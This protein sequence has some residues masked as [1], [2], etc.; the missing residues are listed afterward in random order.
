MNDKTDFTTLSPYQND[1]WIQELHRPGTPQLTISLVQQL[2]ETTDY[3]RL[4]EIC[5]QVL[6]E[7]PAL[8][9]RFLDRQGETRICRVASEA[10]IAVYT[11]DNTPE[12]E[13]FLEAWTLRCWQPEEEPLIEVAILRSPHVSGILM[14]AHHVLSD[15]WGLN[16]LIERIME[17]YGEGRYKS[18]LLTLARRGMKTPSIWEGAFDALLNDIVT[19][20]PALFPAVTRE[21]VYQPDYFK[22]IF[23]DPAALKTAQNLGFSPLVMVGAC[24][25]VL[26]SNLHNRTSFFLGVPCLNRTRDIVDQVIHRANTLP[27]IVEASPDITLHEVA[28]YFRERVKSLKRCEHVPLGKLISALPPTYP[29]RQLFDVTVSYVHVPLS[30]ELSSRRGRINTHIGDA[31]AILISKGDGDDVLVDFSLAPAAFTDD[32]RPEDFVAALEMLMTRFAENVERPVRDIDIQGSL[33]QQQV[34]QDFEQGEARPLPQ[35]RTVLTAFAEAVQRVPDNI[36]VRD[37]QGAAVSYREL[38]E[39]SSAIAGLLRQKGIVRGDIVAVGLPRSAAMVAAMYGVIRAGAAYLPLDSE[40]PVERI[41]HMLDDSRAKLLIADSSFPF[42]GDGPERLD[43]ADIAAQ[44]LPAADRIDLSEPDGLAYVIY[45]SGST[46][47][48]KGVMIEHRA[49]LNRLDWMQ[50]RYALKETDVILQKTPISFD[51]SVWELFWWAMQGASVALPQPGAQRDPREIARAIERFGVTLLHFVPSMFELYVQMLWQDRK[52]LA[53]SRSVARIFTSGEALVPSLVNQFRRLYENARLTLP[54]LSNLYGPT[55]AAIDVSYH[56]IAFTRGTDVLEVP[57]GRPVHNTRLRV[58]SAHGVRQPVGVVGE[59]QIAGVQLARGYLNQP[60]LTAEKFIQADDGQRWY[61]TGDLA[62]WSR[63]GELLYRGRIDGQVKIRGNRIE[64]GEIRRCLLTIP[65]VTGAEVIVGHD[66]ARGNHLVAFY[67]SAQPLDHGLVRESLAYQLPAF[68]LPTVIRWIDGIPLTLNGKVD[69]QAL[70]AAL[71]KQASAPHARHSLTAAETL[72]ADVWREVLGV[73]EIAAGDD[74]FMLGG[75]SLLMLKVRSKLEERGYGVNLT[76]MTRHTTVDGLARLLERPLD[77]PVEPV[78]PLSPFELVDDAEKP[79]LADYVDAYPLSRLQLGLIYHSLETAGSRQYKDVF[80]Y[81]LRMEWDEERFGTALATLIA[82]HPALR[83]IFD[84]HRFSQ[85]MQLICPD[86]AIER[87]LSVQHVAASERDKLIRRWM[88]EMAEHHYAFEQAPPY[89]VT[90]FI[91]AGSDEVELVLNF[92]H[93]LLDGGSVAN[94]LSELLLE[95]ATADAAALGYPPAELP[96]PSLFIRNEQKALESEEQRQYWRDYLNGAPNTS[97][98]ALARYRSPSSYRQRISRGLLLEQWLDTRL[99]QMSLSERIPVRSLLLTAHCVVIGLLSASSEVV[100]GVVTH[101]RP[102]LK[103]SER[104]LGLFLNTLPVRFDAEGKSWRE[105][106]QALHEAERSHHAHRQMPLS[107]I[108]ELNPGFTLNTAFNYIHYHMLKDA[109]TG[110][111][112]ELTGFEPHEETNFTLLVNVMRDFSTDRTML[113]VDLDGSQLAEEQA[114]HYLA[115]F[116]QVLERMALRPE[117]PARLSCLP[118]EIGFSWSTDEARRFVPVIEHIRERVREMPTAVAIRH[119]ENSWTYQELWANSGQI[120]ARLQEQ[121]VDRHAVVGIAL[122]RSPQLIATLLATLRLGAACLP[123]DVAYP[124]SR[125]ADIIERAAPRLIAAP[126]GM[127]ADWLPDGLRIT[128]DALETSMSSRAD[129]FTEP[130]VEEDDIAYILFTSGS[131]GRPKGVAM[132]Q[133]ALANMIEWQNTM[134]SGHQVTST[135]QYAPL[136]FDVSFQEIFSTLCAG[137]LLCLIDEERRRDPVALLRLIAEQRIERVFLPYVALQQM[138]ETATSLNLIPE[139]LRILISAGEQLRVTDEIRRFIGALR[140]GILENHYGPTET[141]VV[142]C[143]RMAGQ[144]D[145]FP[146]LPPIGQPIANV[147][148]LILNDSLEVVPDGVCGELCFFGPALAL[149]YYGDPQETEKK[150]FSLPAP[151]NLRIYRTGDTGVRLASGEIVCLGR[152]DSQIKVRGYRVEPAE[153]EIRALRFLESIGVTS[154]LA[155]LARTR[156]N[157][158]AYLVLYLTGTPDDALAARLQE[159]LAA[160]LPSYMLPSAI[161]WVEAIPRTPSGKRDDAALRQREPVF[162]PAVARAPRNECEAR[163]CQMLGEL[164]AFPEISPEQNIFDLGATSLTAMRVVVMVEKVY[165]VN[166]PLAAFIKWPTVS[167]LAEI[168]RLG[169]QD[170]QPFDPLVPMRT[171]GTNRPIFMVHPMGGN[172]LSYLKMLRH[173]PADQPFYALQSPGVEAGSAPLLGI[174]NQADLYIQAIKRVQPEGPYV[175]AGWSYGGF[176]AFEMARRLLAAG[177]RVER[178]IVL[179]TILPDRTSR[180]NFSD[181]AL[182]RWFFWEL[183]WVSS[184]ADIT[185]ELIPETVTSLQQRFDYMADYAVRI[186]ALPAGSDSAAIQR[187]F[188]VYRTNWRSAELFENDRAAVDIT[189]IRAT[190]PL[191]VALREMHERAGTRY[192]DPC[193]GWCNETSGHIEVIEVDGDHLTIMEEPCVGVVVERIVELLNVVQEEVV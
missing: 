46:G 160:S 41:A 67:V 40:Y 30:S 12:Q 73:N 94:L 3:E 88:W 9:H 131:T 11:F 91:A 65:G 189:L 48:P 188:D 21:Q 38:D 35:G 60:E 118:E 39:W 4:R 33:A 57:I 100:T 10:E 6:Q 13:R 66:E 62:C 115:L 101:A 51:V 182:L 69:H 105:C 127:A 140:D 99:Q 167:R 193:N 98:V 43:I 169:R 27:V 52:S 86:L 192:D 163:L 124:P 172:V 141:H 68:M 92:H 180:E 135:L 112:I 53:A 25:M 26:L 1:V 74:F 147:G 106:V 23:I 133:R 175:L 171:A 146:G 164:L 125:L 126:H 75:D 80:R 84:L 168:I 54:A 45:T 120:A 129:G 121:G 59:L 183:L 184:G 83:T 156:G 134:P 64:L 151:L 158:D 176:V 143:H 15:A 70:R 138:A 136:S 179:D 18:R 50:E 132:P 117:A 24:L 97:P 63:D 130:A 113:R 104:L 181:D 44:K 32:F 34:T 47:Q 19:V 155:V 103:H 61:R 58:V 89:G 96:S 153:V 116:Q 109:F 157:N 28:A 166:V 159:A 77:V 42:G 114:G 119:G 14:R 170:E 20:E 110:K 144:V 187:L 149:G 165:G 185:A 102:E 128:V 8:A 76:D 37:A 122:E 190:Q 137:G 174:G 142:T 152:N 16:V 173:L 31:A 71:A 93:A 162:R 5:R 191:P 95:Y 2:P 56:D 29:S 186:G 111:G 178:L 123:L 107:A 148:A 90:V 154:E 161:E 82:R 150:F 79:L 81:T 49:L 78:R 22:R 87:V 55:E 36:A 85:P 139:S 177:E 72:V 108:A 145:D 7:E 17:R